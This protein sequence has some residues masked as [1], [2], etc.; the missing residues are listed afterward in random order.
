MNQNHKKKVE[1][2]PVAKKVV[3]KIIAKKTTTKKSP[4]KAK[5]VLDSGFGAFF[6]ESTLDGPKRSSGSFNLFQ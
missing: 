2:K 3:K 1:K 4:A 5:K 6:G